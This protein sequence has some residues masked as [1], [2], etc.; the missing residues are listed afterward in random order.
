M[1]PINKTIGGALTTECESNVLGKVGVI[2]GAQTGPYQANPVGASGY[3]AGSW[4]KVTGSSPEDQ[5]VS[6]YPQ[7]LQGNYVVD[8]AID[9]HLLR[10]DPIGAQKGRN[11]PEKQKFLCALCRQKRWVI[12]S[13]ANCAAEMHVVHASLCMRRT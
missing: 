3:Q 2:R 4:S 1:S 8:G 10:T 12:H 11:G 6:H 13:E 9:T 7:E 5:G